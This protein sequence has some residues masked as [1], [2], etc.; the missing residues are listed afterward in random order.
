MYP[1]NVR[2]RT[3]TTVTTMAESGRER[4]R[5][6]DRISGESLVQFSGCRMQGV[7]PSHSVVIQ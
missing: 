3:S 6:M 2:D 4:E 1:S 7:C 5:E